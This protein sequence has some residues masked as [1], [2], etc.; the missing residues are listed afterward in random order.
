MRDLLLLDA[1]CCSAVAQR[2]G[3]KPLS[4]QVK[5]DGLIWIKLFDQITPALPVPSMPPAPLSTR[6]FPPPWSAE[7]QPNHYVVRD[8]NKQPLAYVYYENEPVRRSA[9]KPLSRG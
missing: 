7:L 4:A 2:E 3:Q 5:P 8:A 1:M 6:R 9:A